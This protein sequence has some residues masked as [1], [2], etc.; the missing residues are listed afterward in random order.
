[1]NTR[2]TNVRPDRSKLPNGSIEEVEFEFSLLH[3]VA[4]IGPR[5]FALMV[6]LTRDK[7]QNGEHFKGTAAHPDLDSG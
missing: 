1:M 5:Q 3:C 7:E 4:E 6:G 2:P